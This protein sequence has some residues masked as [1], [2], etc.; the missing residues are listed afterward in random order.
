MNS[1]SR[2][3]VFSKGS[4]L[5]SNKVSKFKASLYAPFVHSVKN[6]ASKQFSDGFFSETKLLF[7]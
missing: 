1:K 6:C 5:R 2:A 3:K 7:F 4:T